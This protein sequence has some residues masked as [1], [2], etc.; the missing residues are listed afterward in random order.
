MAANFYFIAAASGST[1]KARILKLDALGNA[2]AWT[3]SIFADLPTIVDATVAAGEVTLDEAL[4]DTG[5]ATG[6]YK[7][8]FPAAI[9]AGV[10]T[11]QLRIGGAH[12]Q[13]R[14]V[15][16]DGSTVTADKTGYKLASDGLDSIS[17]TAPSGVASNFREMVIATW[18]RFYKKVTKD[19]DEIKTYAD[20]GSTV[21][22]TQT[23]TSSD[24][25][26]DVGA[27]S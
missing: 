26:D 9:A 8:E 7:G 25:N 15:Y 22:T 21:L 14:E 10:Y 1:P 5:T 19:S 24:P 11:L 2:E 18:R 13:S 12:S 23:Y 4:T 20:N 27:A 16:W 6:F 17:T 3:G